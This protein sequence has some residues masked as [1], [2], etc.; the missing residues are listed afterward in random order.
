MADL[1]NQSHDFL[2]GV[3]IH[4]EW[5][6]DYLNPDMDAFWDVVFSDILKRIGA[7]RANT[8]LDAGCGYCY[9][10]VRLARSGAKITAVD[11]SSSALEAAR[12]NISRAGIAEQVTLQQA[13][14]TS[15]P[16]PDASFDFVV[17]NGVLMHIPELE[18]ALSELARVLKPNGILVLNENNA[19][20]L[21]VR[22]RERL[23]GFI[24]TAL[25]RNSDQTVLTPRGTE[26]WKKGSTGGLM[27]RKTN[28]KFLTNFLS[29]R[30]LRQVARTPSQFTEAYTNL[31][32]K[33]LKR[34][35]YAFNLF[36]FRQNMS[37]S[38]SMGNILYFRAGNVG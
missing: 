5:E 8:I 11:F 38:M 3:R 23:I 31:P 27:V 24:K 16:F 4:S 2:Q 35:V 15:L 20:S 21:D 1:S 34:A 17:S 32:F 13:N 19:D 26:T 6:S 37:P 12:N 18:S 22:F 10:T 14:L 25:A 36:C 7:T 30:G 9:H 28:M 33:S 29:E